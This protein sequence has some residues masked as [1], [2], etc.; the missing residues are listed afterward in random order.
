M[1]FQK[2]QII[3]AFFLLWTFIQLCSYGTGAFEISDNTFPDIQV[4]PQGSGLKEIPKNQTFQALPLDPAVYYG[5][6]QSKR[7]KTK[8]KRKNGG[9]N[10]N[11]KDLTGSFSDSGYGQ[12]SNTLK[13]AF[14]QP[15]TPPDG[16]QVET[17]KPPSSVS[18]FNFMN[19]AL[20]AITIGA[21]LVI[22]FDLKFNKIQIFLHNSNSDTN[23]C[24]AV[25]E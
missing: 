21:N 12:K 2:V 24:S 13:Y 11:K 15:Q 10:N 17:C 3:R 7:Q 5:R 23:V 25:F 9:N 8:K 22:H 6:L 18:A 16:G 4:L 1:K 19:F 14:L 20:A